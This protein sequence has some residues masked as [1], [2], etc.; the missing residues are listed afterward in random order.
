MRG[1]CKTSFL[2]GAST[3]QTSSAI[4]RGSS[5]QVPQRQ[6]GTSEIERLVKERNERGE[7]DADHY[8]LKHP[9]W[10][11]Y[12]VKTVEITHRE[13]T[14]FLDKFAYRMIKTI[15]F[16]FDIMS[17]FSILKHNEKIWLNR[18]IFLETVAAVPGSIAAT[19]RHLGALRNMER[20]HGWIHTLLEEA[21][22]ERLHLLTAVNVRRPGKIF[23]LAVFLSQGLFYNFFFVSYLISP[24]FCHRLVG[25]LEEEAV[26]TYTKCLE[27]IESGPLTHWK[28][29]PAPEV[30]RQ[31]WHLGENAT[32]RDVILVIR[33][34]EAHHRLVNHTFA[35]MD[36]LE[37]NPFP[38]GH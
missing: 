33:A 13:P 36:K 25:Y 12:D 19:L 17:G 8:T 32:M 38:P 28:T 34:D 29:M 20:D 5:F 37:D 10:N 18:I 24:K 9:L 14:S 22:N 35:S 6:L 1:A 4:S 27:E 2:A 7:K 30:A 16:N 21:E 23:R 3:F 11:D 31:Y 15:R 26:K